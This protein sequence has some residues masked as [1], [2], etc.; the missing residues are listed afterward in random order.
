MSLTLNTQLL[1]KELPVAPAL[2]RATQVRHKSVWLLLLSSALPFL[3][4][5]DCLWQCAAL[6]HQGPCNTRL[7]NGRVNSGVGGAPAQFQ[8]ER[9]AV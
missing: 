6:H 2:M 5:S 9:A 3:F 1:L 7:P 4:V 8:E